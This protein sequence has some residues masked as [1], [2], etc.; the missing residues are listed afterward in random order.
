M[1]L[2]TLGA[3]ILPNMLAGKGVIRAVKRTFM[4]GEITVRA[5][6]DS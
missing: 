5:D 2:S 4:A 3:I 6:Q 1:L